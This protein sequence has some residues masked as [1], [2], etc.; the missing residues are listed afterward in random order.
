MKNRI[1]WSGIFLAAGM[2]LSVA[3]CWQA[4]S[5]TN[6]FD[7]ALNDDVPSALK[8]GSDLRARAAAAESDLKSPLEQQLAAL[9]KTQK[10]QQDELKKTIGS[11]EEL[12]RRN[13]ELQ[14]SLKL[15]EERIAKIRRVMR[16]I[17]DDA[18]ETGAAGGSLSSGALLAMEGDADKT[19]LASNDVHLN[20][21]APAD[22]DQWS[23]E[24]K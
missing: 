14:S 10:S 7:Q 19:P 18:P 2:A 8:N 11:A 23:K 4:E 16:M 24:I 1:R 9:R 3:G 13:A 15:T 6:P 20:R 22:H 5:N 12:A 21:P 17:S